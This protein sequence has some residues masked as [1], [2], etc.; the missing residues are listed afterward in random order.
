[1]SVAFQPILDVRGNRTAGWEILARFTRGPDV[2]TDRWFESAYAH[3]LGIPLEAYVLSR[4]L[5]G[6]R[7][8]PPGTFMTL[9]V[10]PDA[11]GDPAI[12]RMITTQ[13][14]LHGLIIELTEQLN[15]RRARRR[16]WQAACERLRRHGAMIAIDD[17]GTGYAELAEIL[18]LRPDVIKL[19]RSVVATV[20]RD[21]AQQA[22]VRFLG[23]FCGHLDA[24]VLAEGV[25]RKG[26]LAVL[27]D[28]GV[29]LAQGWFT[30]RPAPVPRPCPAELTR[31]GSPTTSR[32]G[33]ASALA[34]PAALTWDDLAR[35][36]EP[37]VR[38][39][40]LGRPI[41][42]SVPEDDGRPGTPRPVNL[43]ISPDLALVETARRAMARPGPDR[44]DPIVCIDAVG[45]VLG[46]VTVADLMLALSDARA[47]G[48]AVD[49]A[50]PVTI[51][52]RRRR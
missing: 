41:S 4:V 42:V 9:N 5:P 13:A 51:P 26:Q 47:T 17:L 38:L 40:P 37:V 11:L 44:F 16:C 3:G 50:R 18:A 48:P 14:P 20:D 1:V 29:P 30:G 2:G 36:D 45:R 28:L 33:T 15:P 35:G 34:R 49:P 21:P 46:I 39:D 52:S 25:E 24:W 31:N 27:A 43:M 22:L 23:D 32:P 6:L 7:L 19:D 10:T 8:R 12:E